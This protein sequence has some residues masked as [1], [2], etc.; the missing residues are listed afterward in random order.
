MTTLTD[1]D[2][3][4]GWPRVPKAPAPTSDAVR[5]VMRGNRKSGT[6]PELR[7][8]SALYRAGL[9]YRL[10]FR[11]VVGDAAVRPDVA[12]PRRRLAV[13]V[14][15]CFWHSCPEHGTQ[16]QA[17]HAYWRA[18]LARNQARD[19]WVDAALRENL[20]TVIRIWEHED[21]GD[22]ARRVRDGLVAIADG[23]G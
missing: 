16:P 9:R 13:F 3:R 2:L 10:G 11:V 14:D 5:S 20:W 8:R 7:L 18:K 22:A 6:T 21:P 1:Q 17:N 4:A 12:F 15:G 19:R 23:A